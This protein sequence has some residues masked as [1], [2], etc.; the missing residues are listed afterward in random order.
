MKLLATICSAALLGAALAPAHAFPAGSPARPA[1]AVVLT[2]WA[3]GPGY[4]IGAGGRRCWPNGRAP[5]AEIPYG[6]VVPPPLPQYAVNP[7]PIL[8]CPP[9]YHLGRGLRRCWPN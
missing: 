2:D 6:Y 8:E 7:P 1:P 4:H 3:C 5:L 9:G